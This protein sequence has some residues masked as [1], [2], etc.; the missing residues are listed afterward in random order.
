[1]ETNGKSDSIELKRVVMVKAVVTE[2]FRDNLAQ[3]LDRAAKR[4]DTQLQ[5]MEFQAKKHAEG[6]KKKGLAQQLSA[7]KQQYEQ[8]KAKQLAAKADLLSKIEQAQALELGSLFV[9][10]PIE[11]PVTVSAGDNLYKKVGGAEIIV[12]DGVIQE[13]R[14]A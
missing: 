1:M 4:I 7:F 11:G 13:I 14:T 3:E 5:Q 6:L 10:G 8:E 12:K 2:S 9:Q